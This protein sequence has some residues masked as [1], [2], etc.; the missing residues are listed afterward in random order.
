M[1]QKHPFK[2]MRGLPE[3]DQYFLDARWRQMSELIY[4]DHEAA[5][6]LI[7]NRGKWKE[8]YFVWDEDDDCLRWERVELYE[9]RNP[10][11]IGQDKG[12]IDNHRQSDASGDRGEW[13]LDNSGN[14]NLY[15]GKFDNR[16][17]LY[18]AEWGCWR[19]DQAAL[20]FQGM[21]GIYENYGPGRTQAEPKKFAT[22]K[23]T[24]TDNNGFIDQI[25]YDINGD[26][27]FD[28]KVSLKVLGIDDKNTVIN[29]AGMKYKDFTKL[30]TKM[31]DLQWKNAV[32]AVEIAKQA[33]LNV[34][35]YALM[36]HPKSVREKNNYGYW[37]QF[38]LYRDLMDLAK[39]EKN[40]TY[41]SFLD[42]AYYSG[43]W[44]LLQ[45][46]KVK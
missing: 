5:W 4:P 26:T 45:G 42:K 2:H 37:L 40:E 8:V 15:I 11:L 13:D 7:F 46:K 35:W 30:K 39:R 22:I 21:G 43:N 34:S 44:N 32:A 17:H 12:G 9:P 18:G 24:D 27:L 25:E 19:I 20:S 6:D 3:A 31:A 33:G 41:L 16:I 29:T 23:Y 36:M 28:H 38:Y 10:F 1:D 14:G